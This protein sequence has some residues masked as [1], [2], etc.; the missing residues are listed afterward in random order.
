MTQAPQWGWHDWQ[1][2]AAEVKARRRRL[3]LSQIALAARARV[4]RSTITSLEQGAN[5]GYRDETLHAVARAL[6]WGWDSLHRILNGQQPQRPGFSAD[7]RL[8]D[9]AE[10]VKTLSDSEARREVARVLGRFPGNSQHSGHDAA[11]A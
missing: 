4:S 1:R 10:W 5:P 11:S 8:G 9:W 7:D 3:G 2:L 6:E